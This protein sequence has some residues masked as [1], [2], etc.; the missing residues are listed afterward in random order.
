MALFVD[1]EEMTVAVMFRF[2][3]DDGWRGWRCLSIM[4]MLC[5]FKIKDR[6][7]KMATSKIHRPAYEQCPLQIGGDSN[8]KHILI[9]ITD[10]WG[11]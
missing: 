3:G 10:L 5:C 2:V 8:L 11:T 4:R 7:R 6:E 1:G 9:E